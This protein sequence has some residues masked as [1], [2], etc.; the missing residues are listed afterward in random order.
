[1]SCS[2]GCKL[3]LQ[4]V[5]FLL[6]RGQDPSVL[7]KYPRGQLGPSLPFLP[8]PISQLAAC[9]SCLFCFSV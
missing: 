5:S 8:Y 2:L 3:R 6:W 7:T 1:M 9:A 4:S